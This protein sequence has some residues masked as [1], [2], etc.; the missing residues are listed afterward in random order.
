MFRNNLKFFVRV[1]LKDRFYSLLNILGLALG[2]SV[3]IVLLLILQNDL[4]YDQ[5][6]AKHAQIYRLGT[7]LQATGLDIKV[8]RASRELGRILQEEV[9]EVQSFVRANDW[10]R[11]MVKYS[12]ETGDEKIFYEENVV[13]TDSN[14][15]E[16]FTHGFIAGNPKTCLADI[17]TLVLTQTTA[18]RYF[19]DEDPI[20]KSMMINSDLYKVTGVIQDLPDNS[21]LKFDILLSQ[22][23][24]RPWVVERTQSGE[25]ISEA[26]W[27]PDV[28]LYLLFPED[29][30]LKDFEPRYKAI[31]D[32][33]YKP[34]GDQVGGVYTPPIMESLASIH[35]NSTLESDEPHGNKAYLYAFTGIGFFIILL[36][37]INYMNLSTARAVNRASEIAMKKTLGSDRRSLV[38]SFLGESVLLSCAAL[39]VA[40]LIV[41]VVLHGTPFN[42]LIGKNLS[43]DFLGNPLLL[44]G[45]I[46]LAIG[47]GILSGVYP[48]LY[49]PTIP[50]IKAL[51]GEYKNQKSGLALRRVL[52]TVQFAISI[53]VVVCTLF[54]KDQI[55]FVRS[56]EL[57]FDKENVLLLPV[58]D[59]L[60]QNQ[61]P[62]IKHEFLQYPSITGATTSYG[63]PGMN[64]RGAT[65]MWAETEE[66]MVQQQFKLLAVGEDYLKTMNISLVDGRDFEKGP[67]A[68]VG[69]SFI[70]NE[71]AAKLMGWTGEPVG[72]K[73]KFFHAKEDSHVIGLVKDFNFASLHNPVEPLLLFKVGKEGGY[74]HLK[75]SDNLPQTIRHIQEKWA[76]FDPNHPF[77]Y[78]FLDQRFNEQYKEDETQHQL[79]SGLAYICIFIS[80]LGLL[81]LSAFS[82]T[83]RTKEIGIRKVLGASVPG[84]IYLL[85][86]DV[87]YLVIIAAVLVVPV[88]YY[89]ITDWL[90]NFAYQASL[91]YTLFVWAGVM[92]LVFAFLTVG[93][94]SLR[95]AMTN[96]VRSLKYE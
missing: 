12:P 4:T 71:A 38:I 24:D 29:Y 88:T 8:A 17:N 10:S 79:L 1:F 6:H 62:A 87:M 46:G 9:P 13:R 20:D 33:Y 27:N 86:K 89:V 90:G 22:L 72:K 54:M 80:L 78:F 34:F 60:V 67:S 11:V 84:I 68:D 51:K 91:N 19:G 83:Q 61:L 53:F 48:A 21:H 75:I 70:A 64:I 42:Q 57:G 92:A 47:I 15:F 76:Q 50:T 32:K 43:A 96:P 94:H 56:K 39:L 26:F 69:N 31:F 25:S 41:V 28:Y 85:Y 66:G 36:A 58:Q 40:V 73:V 35:F 5:H 2:I 82:A 45:G 63:V 23:P 81:G 59:T 3:S 14:F 30:D 18:K 65:V 16:L 95:T 37:C 55:D 44:L 52:I 49:L 77:E 93:F 74:L 7:H